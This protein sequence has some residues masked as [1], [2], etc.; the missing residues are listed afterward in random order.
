MSTQLKY[1][2]VEQYLRTFSIKE[3]PYDFGSLLQLLLA[4]IENLRNNMVDGDILDYAHLITDDQAKLLQQ[5]LERRA[6]STELFVHEIT[7]S[8]QVLHGL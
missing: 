7:H 3:L 1:E 6:E 4:G 2:D 8:S 5:L